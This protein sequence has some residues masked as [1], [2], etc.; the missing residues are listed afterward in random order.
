MRKKL[1]NNLGLKL[2]SLV[3]AI[4]LWFLVVQIEDPQ[5]SASF[6]NVQVKLINTELLEQEGKVYEVLENTDIARVKV[7]APRS[8]ISQIRETDIVAEADVSKLT[9]INTIAINYYVEN[10]AVDR[11]EGS[12]EVV[13]LSVEEKASKWIRLV[14]NTVGEVAEGYMIYNSSLDQTNIEISGPQS[15]VSQVEYAAVDMGVSG[16][17]TSLSANV[18]IKLNDSEGK[19]VI[20]NNI[21]KN[22]NSAYMTIEVLATKDVPIEVRSMGEAKEGYMATGVV[23]S[24]MATV[25]LAAKPSVLENINVITIPEER[26]DITGA[27]A[28]VEEIIDLDDYLPD[29]VRFADKAFNGKITVTA[30]VEPIVSKEIEVPVANIA[31]NNVPEG[32]EVEWPNDVENYSLTISGLWEYINSVQQETI[33]GYVDVAAYMARMNMEELKAGEHIVPVIFRLSDDIIVD[34]QLS[35]SVTFI[36]PDDEDEE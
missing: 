9:D 33:T 3:L 14:G 2:A 8:I 11:V 36:I 21:D 4:V 6:T 7:Y 25:K 20:Q 13:R 35:A 30:F 18:E 16:A 32:F 23:E 10:V 5:D 12:R 28:N 19:E 1:T 29:N 22:V 17:T 31:F 26:L 27:D 34:E 15:A 24:N